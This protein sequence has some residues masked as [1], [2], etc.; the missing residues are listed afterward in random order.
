MRAWEYLERADALISPSASRRVNQYASLEDIVAADIEKIRRELKQFERRAAENGDLAG[1]TASENPYVSSATL[2]GVVFSDG[3]SQFYMRAYLA[4]LDI[5][6]RFREAV[7]RTA[8]NFRVAS[9]EDVEGPDE[10]KAKQDDG[11]DLADASEEWIDLSES[12]KVHVY[13]G[14]FPL[15]EARCDW[16]PPPEK[17]EKVRERF[18]ATL[19]SIDPSEEV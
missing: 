2:R 18:A 14:E 5:E 13:V 11:I 7:V 9:R 15:I 6:S 17:G 4:K 19:R 8:A 12:P 1:A 3:F 16:C 10:E